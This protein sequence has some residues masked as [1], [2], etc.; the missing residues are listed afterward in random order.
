MPTAGSYTMTETSPPPTARRFSPTPVE[1]TVKKVRRFAVEPV[2]TTTRSNKKVEDVPA[3][4]EKKDFAPAKRRFVPVPV[5]TTFKSN[6]QSANPLPTPEHT[7]VSIPQ[8]TPKEETP[9]PRRKF[10]PELIETTK[11]SKKA[12]DSRPATLPTDKVCNTSL[13]MS[14]HTDQGSLN[15]LISL[16]E[17]QIFILERNESPALPWLQFLPTILP[18]RVL[19]ISTSYL[20]E[21][22]PP[23]GHTQ[24]Q[25]EVQGKIPSNLSWKILPPPRRIRKMR[26]ARPH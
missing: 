20:L 11:R 21:D 24:T 10:V 17:C 23:C 19:Q 16:L 6:R 4:I 8:E 13:H 2:E 7:P 3:A 1:T 5:E 18:T 26:M 22:S 25:D 9:K 15:R 14:N 12:G